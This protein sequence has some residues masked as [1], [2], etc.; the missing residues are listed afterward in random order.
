M[1]DSGSCPPRREAAGTLFADAYASAAK[2]TAMPTPRDGSAGASCESQPGCT[3]L[4]LRA[5]PLF[6][7]LELHPGDAAVDHAE[8]C[9]GGMRDVDHAPG[10]ERAAVVD[11]DGDGLPG[12]DVGHAQAGPERQRA[13]RGGQ[14]TRLELLPARG[15]RFI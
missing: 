5:P 6:L 2:R 13:V 1:T 11:P 10:H 4:E 7:H 3:R 8:R 14:L 9:G 15:L 12:G